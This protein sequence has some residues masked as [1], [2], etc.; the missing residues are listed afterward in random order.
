M[1]PAIAYRIVSGPPE[2]SQKAH[3]TSRLKYK[4][5]WK[6]TGKE[7]VFEQTLRVKALTIPHAEYKALRDFLEK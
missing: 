1:A 4:A 7:L 2:I 3:A 6:V 5:S